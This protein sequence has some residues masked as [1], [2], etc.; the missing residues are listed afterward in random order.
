MLRHFSHLILTHP[1]KLGLGEIKELAHSHSAFKERSQDLNVPLWFTAC[2]LRSADTWGWDIELWDDPVRSCLNRL[3][4]SAENPLASREGQVRQGGSR[5]N[6]EASG[7]G[8]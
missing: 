3:G 8:W 4:G 7:I 1:T 5:T 6:P 2:I